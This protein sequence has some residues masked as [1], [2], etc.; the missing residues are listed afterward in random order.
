MGDYHMFSQSG[1][2][3]NLKVR[4]DFCVEVRLDSGTSWPSPVSVSLEST[5][6]FKF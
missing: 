1:G 4:A 5:L 3:Y 2:R 6:V